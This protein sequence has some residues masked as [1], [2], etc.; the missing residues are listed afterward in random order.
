MV[1]DF[2]DRVVESRRLV[3]G[4]LR[5]TIEDTVT[6]VADAAHRASGLRAR[7]IAAVEDQMEAIEGRLSRLAELDSDS[8]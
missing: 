8:R 5:T 2:N 7:G 3:E 6:L 1:G 4:A